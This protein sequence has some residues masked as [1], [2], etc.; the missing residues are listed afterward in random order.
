M[1]R[2]FEGKIEGLDVRLDI[3]NEAGRG[4]KGERMQPE[5][6][7]GAG[8]NDAFILGYVDLEV[9]CE[10]SDGWLLMSA[11]SLRSIRRDTSHHEWLR[12]QDS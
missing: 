9:S 5:E 11:Q 4:T 7:R 1:G 12:M 10:T 2:Y 6:F 8:W 3:V